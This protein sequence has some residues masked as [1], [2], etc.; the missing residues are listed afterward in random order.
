LAANTGSYT[1][2]LIV[3]FAWNITGFWLS[4][5]LPGAGLDSVAG[6]VT[7]MCGFTFWSFLGLLTLPTLSRQASLQIDHE[8]MRHG[9]P[10]DLISKTASSVDR[11]QDD[12]PERSPLI[13]TIFHP[14][15]SVT[16]R[17]R[18]EP[19]KGFVTWNVARTTLFFSW[20][21]FSF[22]SRSVHCNLGRPALWLM[23]P[24]D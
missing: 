16:G 3:A 23:L 4:S 20:A 2:G 14:V 5:L 9:V 8:L 22:L 15:P 21:C 13:E 1:R 7:T 24:T 11:F 10:F 12:E 17:C 19:V 18:H 6:L